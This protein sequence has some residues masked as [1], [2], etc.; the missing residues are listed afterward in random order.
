MVRSLLCRGHLAS[1]LKRALSVF[2]ILHGP[3]PAH[4]RPSDLRLDLGA[5]V[6][7]LS[8][9]QR[10]QK[11][12]VIES[13][14][15]RH[16]EP[17]DTEPVGWCWVLLCDLGGACAFSPEARLGY[18]LIPASYTQAVLDG[19]GFALDVVVHWPDMRVRVPRFSQQEIVSVSEWQL[20]PWFQARLASLSL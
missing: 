10:R 5:G 14:L 1:K 15:L 4:G 6:V 9:R 13:E 12:V 11:L 7:A 16:L 17:F 20:L 3:L 19:L 8:M 18:D 2:I